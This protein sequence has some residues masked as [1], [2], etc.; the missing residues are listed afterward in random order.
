MQSYAERWKLQ[1]AQGFEAHTCCL[2][3]RLI[4]SFSADDIIHLVTDSMYITTS[5]DIPLV[6][7]SPN[8]N[9]IEI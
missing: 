2:I 5:Y 1:S 9:V 8:I 4:I 6:F 3:Q 7:R